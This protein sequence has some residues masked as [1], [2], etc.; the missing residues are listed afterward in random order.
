MMQ[1]LYFFCANASTFSNWEIEAGYKASFGR[2]QICLA[3]VFFWSHNPFLL[4][5]HPYSLELTHLTDFA[6]LVVR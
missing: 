1:D 6:D 4:D 5:F 2:F 3:I